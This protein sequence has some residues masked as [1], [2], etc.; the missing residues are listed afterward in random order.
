M[1]S[2]C[3]KGT[4]AAWTADAPLR[5][6]IEG[7]G[8]LEIRPGGTDLDARSAKEQDARHALASELERLG[9]ASVAE[10]E[11]RFARRTGLAAQLE[12]AEPLLAEAAPDGVS[13]LEEEQRAR[14][15]ERA[16]LGE[17]DAGGA[18]IGDAEA[19]LAEATDGATRARGERDAFARGAGSRRRKLSQRSEQA[20]AELDA[21]TDGRCGAARGAPHP[22]SARH[23]APR[24]AERVGR[25]GRS[26]RGARGGAGANP[27]TGAELGLEQETR[28]LERLETERA[29]EARA[30]RSPRRHRPGPRR[31]RILHE[32]VQR[33][34][35]ELDERAPRRFARSRRALRP[36]ASSSSRS[37]RRGARC[38]S[39]SSL[40]V[41]ERARPYLE[42]LLPGRRLR[43]D[44]N[45][46]RRR[47]SARGT[48]RRT[49]TTSR[50]GR[51]SR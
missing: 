29:D 51:A 11:D 14:A 48:W 7:V 44:E 38:S 36:R 47:D 46:Q 49:S 4:S 21:R 9:V 19:K 15:T 6:V 33:A 20:I 16:A 35:A 45:W 31:P 10:A 27:G 43:M 8:A 17:P 42:S 5:V 12:H 50:A 41:I 34:E 24:G 2:A 22:R 39:A 28:V 13:A 32:R 30:E 3:R 37:T 1:A 23:A 40:P 18:S 26:H 25:R